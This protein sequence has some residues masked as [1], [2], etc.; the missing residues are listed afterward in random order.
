M[1]D[2]SI[3][4]S[5]APY[6][7]SYRDLKGEQKTIRRVPPPKLHQ[8]LPTDIVS[9]K[10]KKNADFDEG[11]E[12]TVTH[13]NPRHANTLQLVNDDGQTTF[14]DYFD[15]NL[16]EEVAPRAGVSSMDRPGSNRYLL[17]P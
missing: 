17:W 2:D 7:I 4:L 8:M 16:E 10:N 11:D 13:I 12:V 3:I 1:S 9:L 5:G 14:M 6:K 15:V